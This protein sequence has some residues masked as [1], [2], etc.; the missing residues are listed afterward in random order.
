[1]TEVKYDSI[2]IGF[3]RG[4]LIDAVVSS[5]EVPVLHRVTP[6]N[7]ISKKK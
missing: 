6:I 4:S 2:R 3:I 5:D 7:V 1:M